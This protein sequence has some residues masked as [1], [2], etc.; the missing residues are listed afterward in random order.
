MR[1][2]YLVLFGLLF[3]AT[4]ARAQQIDKSIFKATMPTVVMVLAVE[5]EDG[6]LVPMASG[7]GTLITRDGSIL[8][9]HHVIYDP[10][11]DRP[12]DLFVVG[13]F[14]SPVREPELICAGRPRHGLLQPALD[15][16]L[17][18]CEF[19]VR[20]E[21][22]PASVWPALP[23]GRSE[24]LTPGERVWVLGYPSVGGSLLQI[25][26]GLITG[27][28]G[29]T[30]GSGRAFMKTDAGITHGNSGGTAIDSEGRLIGVPT[31]YR[32]I[33]EVKATRLVPAGKVGLVR[34]IEYAR[35]LIA[36]AR[37]GWIPQAGAGG[38]PLGSGPNPTQNVDVLVTS[39]V[40]DYISHTPVV[41]AFVVV[42]KPG[43]HVAE[44]EAEHL[45]DA[46]LAWGQT[47]ER[48]E[49]TINAALP[50]GRYGVVIMARDYVPL[51][52]D[53]VLVVTD[54][55]PHVYDPWSEIRLY[56]RQD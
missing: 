36:Q 41:S 4:P 14:Q 46:A 38:S 42:L 49:F 44:A 27:W 10:R 26:A 34:P 18:K 40:V 37:R 15:L 3:A 22:W 2:V 43:H 12:Y 5:V 20:G 16:A 30:G 1:P 35:D 53:G 21:P 50:K 56:R 31:G 51:A 32:R 48:G 25:T 23:V 29:E 54:R 11:N 33:R 52:Q 7:S 24:D 39:R 19:S 8:T 13:R 9:N 45:S 6:R 55:T 47:N 17:I 28:T